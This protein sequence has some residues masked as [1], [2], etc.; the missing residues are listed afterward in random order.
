MLYNENKSSIVIVTPTVS[1]TS[2]LFL[3]DLV[4]ILS[5]IFSNLSVIAGNVNSNDYDKKVK[6]YSLK[7]ETG[8]SLFSRVLNYVY[9][10][11]RIA[12]ALALLRND[13]DLWIFY[14]CLL[15]TSDAADE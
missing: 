14:F 13:V 12:Y 11:V 10:Q 7:Y 4:K 6:V 3:S 2:Y 9:L 15:Y 1:E 8:K 5:P